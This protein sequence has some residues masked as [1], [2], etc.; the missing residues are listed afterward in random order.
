[1][2]DTFKA[3]PSTTLSKNTTFFQHTPDWLHILRPDSPAVE[4]MTDLRRTRALTIA[5]YIPIDTAL[6]K[7]IHCEVRLLLVTDQ[8]H[9][10]IG[11]ITARDILGEKP[12]HYAQKERVSHDHIRVEHVMTPQTQIQTLSYTDVRRASIG[13]IIVT[14]RRMGRQHALVLDRDPTQG[15]VICG[16][17]STT[18]I[19]RH[20]GVDIQPS[21]R[22]QNFAELEALLNEHS[23]VLEAQYF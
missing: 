12:V 20:L 11:L 1:M 19:G 6:Q 5:P 21:G 13:D 22:V 2:S 15:A 8:D 3:L 14:L 17:F 9:T 7:M 16:L 18:K 23:T 10:V 4:V